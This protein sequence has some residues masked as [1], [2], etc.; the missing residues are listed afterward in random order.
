MPLVRSL[1]GATQATRKANQFTVTIIVTLPGFKVGDNTFI[2]SYFIDP[3]RPV[4]LVLLQ[5][6]FFPP[7]PTRILIG[8]R[9]IR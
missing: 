9:Q 8:V 6:I 5:F 3:L 2:K 1:R 4:D 7:C